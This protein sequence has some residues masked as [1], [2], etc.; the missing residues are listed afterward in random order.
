[1]RSK[2]V[3]NGKKYFGLILQIIILIFAPLIYENIGMH[4]GGPLGVRYFYADFFNPKFLGLP[5]LVWFFWIVFILIGYSLTNAFIEFLLKRDYFFH[6]NSISNLILCAFLDGFAV[7]TFDFFIDPV[8]VKFG[9]WVW[10][11][12]SQY[13]YFD[14]PF[15][16]FIGWFVIV[17]TTT[18]L[19]RLIDQTFQIKP[20]EKLV[21]I[22]PYLYLAIVFVSFIL[23]FILFGFE[24]SI[25]S[26]LLSSPIV[27]FSFYTIRAS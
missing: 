20:N 1:D 10:Q 8:S 27:I 7:M 24:L 21:L 9:L 4:Y 2:E 14:V 16:N 15:G 25:T 5:I 11:N 13:S 26:L 18:F 17:S 23:S 6:I 12:N 3:K 19:V 22:S